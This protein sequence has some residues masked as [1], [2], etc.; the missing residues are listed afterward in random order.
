MT[1]NVVDLLALAIVAVA[2][3]SG[4]R[5]GALPQLFAWA[6]VA[7]FMAAVFLALPLAHAWLDGLDPLVRA[8]AVV[9]VFLGAFA[10]GQGL[11]GIIG[12][13]IRDR[14]GRG[15]L[16]ELD[17]LAGALVGVTEGVLVIW[18]ASGLLVAIPNPTIQHEARDSA[19]L[20]QL[21]ASLPPASIVTGRIER[22]LDESGIPRL[23]IGLFP[24][25]AAPSGPVPTDPEAQAIARPALA[26]TVEVHSTACGRA[27]VGSGFVV[28]PHYVVTNAH[29][30]AGGA[31]ISAT[32]DT[33]SSDATVVTFDP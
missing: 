14:L 15:F 21:Q 3:F 12:A 23:F 33:D 8:A 1:F 20:R 5:S 25:P 30:V 28:G 10:F 7:L 16:G 27:F 6:G 26:S 18:L 24:S 13:R 11:G 17:Q 22:L 4:Y 9:G 32:T 31:G 2:G 29:V 19:V